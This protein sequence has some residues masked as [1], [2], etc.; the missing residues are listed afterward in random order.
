MKPDDARHYEGTEPVRGL[1]ERLPAGEHMLWQ[2]APDWR[3]LAR[4]GFRLRMFAAYFGVLLA[5]YGFSLLTDPAGT[6][7]PEQSVLPLVGSAVVALGLI[8]GFAW[9]T[10]KTTV[11]TIT[12][13][14]VV[15]RFGIALPMTW[16]IPF[17]RISNVDL[18]LFASGAGE[19]VITPMADDK[20]SYLT[21]WPHAQPW[22]LRNPRPNLRCIGAAG[23]V[24]QTLAQA[25]VAGGHG[26]ATA[27]MGDTVM[28]D[29]SSPERGQHAPQPA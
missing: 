24:A 5:W 13:R 22:Q 19:L 8:A 3:A 4:H 27:T 11:Y 15:M 1:P 20:F 28:G 2:G 18:K 9:I 26:M 10:S 12:T 16:N 6:P 17:A 21:M 23:Q 25:L 7:A 29:R 14:R